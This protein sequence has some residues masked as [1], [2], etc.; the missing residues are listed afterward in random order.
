MMKKFHR[1]LPNML[2]VLSAGFILTGLLL[3]GDALIALLRDPATIPAALLSDLQTGALLFRANLIVLGGAGLLLSR[4]RVWNAPTPPDTS[5]PVFSRGEWL[6]L[7]LILLAALGLR[8]YRLNTGLWLDEMTTYINYVQKPFGIIATTYD[9]Q[10]QH[11]LFSFLARLSTL[12]FGD[13]AWSLRLP[14]VLFGVGSI[15]AFYLLARQL[16]DRRESLLGAGLM[17]LTYHHIWFSQNARGYTGL[18]F[19]TLLSSWLLVRGLRRPTPGLWLGYAVTASLGVFTQMTMLFVIAGHFIIYLLDLL[20]RRAVRPRGWVGLAYGFVPA[21]LLT[22]QLHALVFPQILADFTKRT[23]GASY[24]EWQ[25][26]LWTVLE[27]I[28]SIRIGAAG[29]VVI[30]AGLIVF[31]IGVASWLRDRPVVPQLFFIPT[32]IVAAVTIAT[33]HNIWPRLF[34]FAMGFG[35]LIALR[36]VMVLPVLLARLR[37]V[38]PQQLAWLGTA[39]GIAILLAASALIPFVYGPKQDYHTAMVFVE[40]HRQPGDAVTTTGLA[41]FAYTRYYQT[42]WQE[43][44][45]VDAL[46]AIRQDAPRTWFLYTFPPHM[47][48]LYPDIL[49]RVEQEFTLVEEFP[50]TLNGGTVFVYLS[51]KS[52]VQTA[53]K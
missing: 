10:N 22:L 12:V 29:W 5:S 45:S 7:G 40:I 35:L 19:W 6:A 18:L 34:F 46:E 39:M 20:R 15:A 44:E 49:N 53:V 11:F 25:N 27:I 52:G 1:I 8:L 17:T 13:G 23:E 24:G 9:S 42:D 36:G 47:R 43:V 3:S 38:D 26:P 51:D 2:T 21:G 31:G 37:Q 30:A 4:L 41:A 48:A 50:G 14:A 16:T 32:V 33:G 28:Q